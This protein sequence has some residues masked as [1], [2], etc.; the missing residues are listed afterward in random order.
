[1][2]SAQAVCFVLARHEGE[3]SWENATV[4]DER[5]ILVMA[6]NEVRDVPAWKE[7]DGAPTR[8]PNSSGSNRLLGCGE[9]HA[10]LRIKGGENLP[11]SCSH[12]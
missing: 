7:M 10:A 2:S 11:L 6:R 1:M 4:S 12:G 8:R 3:I 5:F 9:P